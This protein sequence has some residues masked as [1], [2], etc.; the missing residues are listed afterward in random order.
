MASETIAA[1]GTHPAPSGD[2]PKK[3]ASDRWFAFWLILPTII[4]VIGVSIYPVGYAIWTSFHNKNPAMGLNLWVGLDN[5]R[6]VLNSRD[7]HQALIVTARFAI[8]TVI[9][10][11]ALGLG[12]AL[13]L[14][15][16]FFGRGL[17]R[18]IILVPWAM[19]GTVVGVLW[20]WI[21]DGGY[22]T[23]NGVL[24]RLGLIDEYKAWL[25]AWDI[26]GLGPAALYLVVIAFVWNSA[27]LAALFLL[28]ALQSVP[29]NLYRAAEMDGAGA[30]QR[31]RY[32][33]LPWLRP[34]ILLVL[35]LATIN[36]VMAF[37]LIYFL[38]RGGPGTQT[39][40][41][42]W[43]GYNTIFGFFQF[44]QGTA[45]L[46]ILTLICLILA[47]LYIKVLDRKP[48]EA[49]N[50]A[51][52]TEA[53]V[54]DLEEDLERQRAT[55]AEGLAALSQSTERKAFAAPTRLWANSKSAR[56]WKQRLIYLPAVLIAIWSL[57]PVAWLFIS[58]V[59]PFTDLLSKPPK[60]WPDATLD[61]Y[62][63]I[64]TGATAADTA[65]VPLVAERVPNALWNSFV[66]ASSVTI[67][68][69][70][71][72]SLAGYA[73]ARYSHVEF[74][75]PSLMVM[76]M[77][78]MIPGLAIMVPWF[79]LFSRA[80][81]SN[82]K[83][84]LIISYASFTIPLVLWIMKTYFETIPINLERAAAIDGCGRL[85][86]FFRVVLPLSVPGLIAAGLFAFI[87]A[88]N[89]FIF[90]LNLAQDADSM[91]ITYVIAQLF[92]VVLYGP[93]NYGTL[94]AAGILAILPPVT[95]AFVLQRY[96]VQGL[97]AGSV[98]G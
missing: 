93:Q 65:G 1:P 30:F 74:L 87:T 25:S 38:T 29:Q 6:Y 90:A 10:S 83:Q 89:E 47:F 59:S 88:W 20:A 36:G 35:I 80:G 17:L 48:S 73:Y 44:G 54:S 7:F 76:M 12:V 55:Y 39:T 42:S 26:P 50:L 96:L 24:Y 61:N 14:N 77:T 92:G 78:R 31:F 46:L 85:Q 81:L 66:V 45:I 53:S 52:R 3:R 51:G 70:V 72:G 86:T 41:F 82:T 32:I 68:A 8:F 69:L 4:A 34:M 21:Y 5:Y 91:T 11:L 64:F 27:P 58:S 49:S 40:V 84:G 94:F 98:K 63:R 18:S 19:S 9:L 56:T 15:Q 95:L 22:G 57:A 37:D 28:A 13:V 60:F 43:L 97:T 79:I 75:G 16:R 33:T 2:K 62:R 71:L 23:L 67:I